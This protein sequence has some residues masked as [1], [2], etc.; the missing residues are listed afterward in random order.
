MI[1]I[2]N[3]KNTLI[4]IENCKNTPQVVQISQTDKYVWRGST[5]DSAT[6]L[7][8]YQSVQSVAPGSHQL[9]V[10]YSLIHYMVDPGTASTYKLST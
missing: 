10:T 5:A 9:H 1:R 3:C 2:E 8:C 7:A 4:K 6:G